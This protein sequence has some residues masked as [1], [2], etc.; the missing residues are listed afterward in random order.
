MGYSFEKLDEMVRE[1]ERR[2]RKLRVW[3]NSN[4]EATWAMTFIL[5]KAG[6][7]NEIKRVLESV[8]R[9]ILWSLITHNLSISS[10]K[11]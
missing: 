8:D 2:N 10:H 3:R 7:I 5:L 1:M 9:D 4:G 6:R 11:P